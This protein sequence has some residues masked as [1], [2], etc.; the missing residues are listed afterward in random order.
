VAGG[1]GAGTSGVWGQ[2]VGAAG[3]CAGRGGGLAGWRFGLLRNGKLRECTLA[4]ALFVAFQAMA[5]FVKGVRVHVKIDVGIEEIPK[6]TSCEFCVILLC[7][8]DTK[9][10]FVQSL[11]SSVM[12]LGTPLTGT[13]GRGGETR[14]RSSPKPLCVVQAN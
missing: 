3:R 9:A 12:D 1:A 6:G 4:Q 7:N 5:N 8:G 14:S 10:A 11:V 2:A 13:T